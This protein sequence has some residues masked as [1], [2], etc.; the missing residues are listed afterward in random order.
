MA[1]T[2]LRRSL[3]GS[4]GDLWR[5]CTSVDHIN[6]LP[7]ST[8]HSR[9]KALH[10]HVAKDS[11]QSRGLQ[12]WRHTPRTKP[13]FTTARAYPT[14]GSPVRNHGGGKR[15]VGGPRRPVFVSI[16]ER[17]LNMVKYNALTLLALPWGGRRW[18]RRPRT[19]RRGELRSARLPWQLRWQPR[20]TKRTCRLAAAAVPRVSRPPPRCVSIQWKSRQG[21]KHE[22]LSKCLSA[23][24]EAHIMGV[25]LS[26]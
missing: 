1:G 26:R 14:R 17:G 13:T 25:G 7:R 3:S 24:W 6:P 21:R 2:V 4:M 20:R 10:A 5:G 15:R 23:G 8:H 18:W 19:R 16:A 22:W 12:W 9:V 11:W